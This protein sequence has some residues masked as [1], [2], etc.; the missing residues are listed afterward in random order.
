MRD[1]VGRVDWIIVKIYF[2]LCVSRH[3][4]QF[5]YCDQLISISYRYDFFLLLLF[6][7]CQG[8]RLL[9]A[10]KFPTWQLRVVTALAR[11]DLRVYTEVDRITVLL[12]HLS[13][14]LSNTTIFNVNITIVKYSCCRLT[15]TS[16][17]LFD[18]ENF[19]NKSKK[20]ESKKTKKKSW[21][22]IAIV[23]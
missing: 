10:P 2:F 15:T 22:W 14:V 4:Y 21:Q 18:S 5:N 13:W 11:C 8:T 7:F 19:N 23:V 6:L 20:T 17:C 16:D 9:N 1:V 3:E 12:C